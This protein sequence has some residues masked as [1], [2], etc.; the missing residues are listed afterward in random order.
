M[1][2]SHAEVYTITSYSIITIYHLLPNLIKPN[3][4]K[5]KQQKRTIASLPSRSIAPHFPFSRPSTPLI[6]GKRAPR[7]TGS[8]PRTE[9]PHRHETGM[10]S[11]RA[12]FCVR[13]TPSRHGEYA[14]SGERL[15]VTPSTLH[16]G[17]APPGR[18]LTAPSRRRHG[19]RT[20]KRQN[21]DQGQDDDQK[22]RVTTHES[23]P[24][25][26]RPEYLCRTPG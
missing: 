17:P 15:F 23:R 16:H 18:G 4:S 7:G 26:H 19:P 20:A 14:A 21:Q 22:Q 2:H 3:Q 13:W 9:R 25:T 1:V 5:S 6:T 12:L 10:S 24:A 8:S 11:A